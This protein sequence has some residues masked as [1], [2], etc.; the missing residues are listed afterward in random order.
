MILDYRVL[1]HIII[2]QLMVGYLLERNL[3]DYI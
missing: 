3:E 2:D 1:L